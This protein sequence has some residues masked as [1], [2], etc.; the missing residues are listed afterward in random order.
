MATINAV[1]TIV[2]VFMTFLAVVVELMSL[3]VLIVLYFTVL[4]Y[5]IYVVLWIC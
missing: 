3:L 4:F 1:D 5:S 2:N